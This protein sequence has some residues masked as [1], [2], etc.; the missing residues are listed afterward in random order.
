MVPINTVMASGALSSPAV[1][2]ARSKTP[3][4]FTEQKGWHG[5]RIAS[6]CLID[7]EKNVC[8]YGEING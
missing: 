5:E 6:E 1:G 3:K 7:K 4:R 8:I 2:Q